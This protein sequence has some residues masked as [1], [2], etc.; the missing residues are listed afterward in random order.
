MSDSINS[1]V[2]EH[3]AFYEVWP[4]YVVFERDYAGL[5]PVT[6]R[7]QAGFEVD[8]YGVNRSERLAPPGSNPD[9]ALGYDALKTLAENISQKASDSCCL[10]VVEFPSTA[11]FDTRKHDSVEAVLQI[12]ISH[13][14]GLDKPCGPAEQHALD[15]VEKELAKMGIQRGKKART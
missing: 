6:H 5:A 4:Y 1:L 9:Y 10:E 11:I 15:E 12:I 8:V 2:E 13:G 14:R 3:E 7:V